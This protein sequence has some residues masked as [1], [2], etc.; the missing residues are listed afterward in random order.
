MHHEAFGFLFSHGVFVTLPH[1]LQPD[2]FLSKPW[3]N[4]R[5]N[6]VL[7]APLSKFLRNLT[8]TPKYIGLDTFWNDNIIGVQI[9]RLKKKCPN[10][11]HQQK[12]AA[13]MSYNCSSSMSSTLIAKTHKEP[14]KAFTVP[15]P[16]NLNHTSLWGKHRDNDDLYTLVDTII[17]NK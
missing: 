14:R 9:L 3:V 5:R 2:S 12:N 11:K 8:L 13:Q 1:V 6:W 16:L 17:T 10:Y 15:C 4:T 7:I